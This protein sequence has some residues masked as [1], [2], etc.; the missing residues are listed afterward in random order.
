VT[1]T[2]PGAKR[3]AKV[4][5]SVPGSAFSAPGGE[6]G[7]GQPD[8]A[9]GPAAQQVGPL[10]AAEAVSAV[11]EQAASRAS[12]LAK[13]LGGVVAPSTM[14]TALLYYFGWSHA[15][16]FFNYFGVDS[17]LLGFTPVDYFMRSVGA[18]F[19]PMTVAAS[20]ALVA[21]WGHSAL[22]AQISTGSRPRALRILLPV[23]A[24]AGLALAAGGFLSVFVTTVLSHHLAAAP[25][26]LAFGVVLLEYTVRLRRLLAA[27]RQN[28]GPGKAPEWTAVGEW[29]LV[30][31]LVGLSLF[32]AATDYSAGVG[33]S[34]AIDFVTRL[35]SYPNVVV[36]SA[37]SLS[38]HALGVREIRCQ[39]PQ[40]AYRFRYDGLKLVL[41]SGGQYLF[42]PADWTSDRVA[43]VIP[44]TDSVR[45]EFY[46]ASAIGTLP[47]SAC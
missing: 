35:G 32:W 25:L 22:R 18:L 1:A 14:L 34:R 15:Y 29:A 5:A 16:W 24:I 38:L 47:G 2:R 3:A 12:Q 19:V 36:Y 31:A 40:A 8:S 4:A 39:D 11:P 46:P 13:I 33:R 41:Q 37:Q 26:S 23:T 27:D 20:A 6:P 21:L 28:T 43:I 17:S 9:S 30:F 7:K 45:L 44:R 10:V 42:L